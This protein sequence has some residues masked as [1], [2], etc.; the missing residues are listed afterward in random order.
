VS[1]EKILVSF[2]YEDGNRFVLVVPDLAAFMMTAKSRS[3]VVRKA[4]RYIR[5]TYKSD[6]LKIPTT[7][8]DVYTDEYKKKRGIPNDA[9]LFPL[10]IKVGRRIKKFKRFTSSMDEALFNEIELFCKRRNIKKS[11]LFTQATR[12]YM[13]RYNRRKRTNLQ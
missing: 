4:I 8:A 10:P 3:E 6:L 7:T 12:E 2:V 5:D 1:N 9:M 11:D 13:E